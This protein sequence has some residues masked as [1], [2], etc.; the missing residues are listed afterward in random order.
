MQPPGTSL[1]ETNHAGNYYVTVTDEHGCKDKANITIQQG[2]I[3]VPFISGQLFV[4][5]GYNWP[6][7]ILMASTALGGV[8][9]SLVLRPTAEEVAQREGS[10]FRVQG[11]KSAD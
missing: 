3:P 8:M 9:L 1:V 6:L 11:S 10:R 7:V 4:R 2:H 5:G